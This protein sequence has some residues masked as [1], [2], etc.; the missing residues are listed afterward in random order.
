MQHGQGAPWEVELLQM[1]VGRKAKFLF[2]APMRLHWLVVSFVVEWE[3]H[4]IEGTTV[5]SSRV[6]KG[7]AVWLSFAAN[8]T[9][10]STD[11]FP[12]CSCKK[13]PKSKVL[14][15]IPLLFWKKNIVLFSSNK[16]DRLCTYVF[17]LKYNTVT[18]VS[19][20]LHTCILTYIHTYIHYLPMI[21]VQLKL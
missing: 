5:I 21:R 4:W 18:V 16:N 20:A 6:L 19:S 12:M 17:S 10:K 15:F 1:V 11:S 3:K 13:N 8:M 2:C 7:S 14:Y 9:I